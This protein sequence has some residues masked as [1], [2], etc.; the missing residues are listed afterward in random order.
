M[1]DAERGMHGRYPKVPNLWYR[2][3]ETHQVEVGNYNQP[4]FAVLDRLHWECTEKVDGTNVRIG[5]DG[6]RVRWNGKTDRAQLPDHLTERLEELFGGPENETLFEQALPD[7]SPEHPVT[8]YGEGYGAK[9][10]KGG[11]KYKADG[12]DFALFD[13][14]FGGLWLKRDAIE[15]IAGSLGGI[16]TVPLVGWMTPEEASLKLT[17]HAQSHWPGVSNMIEG[18]VLRAPLGLRNRHGGRIMAKVKREDVR[19]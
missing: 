8:L 1:T 14:R 5:W 7:A 4:E 18:Y 9:I 13:V 6:D 15:D 17:R 19:R 12:C 10:Q 11:G 3:P 2:N 16:D